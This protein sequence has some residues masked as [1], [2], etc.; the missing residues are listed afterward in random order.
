MPVVPWTHLPSLAPVAACL[1]LTVERL[2]SDSAAFP[3]GV[4]GIAMVRDGE[5][6][7]CGLSVDRHMATDGVFTLAWLA[8]PPGAG[9]DVADFLSSFEQ[10]AVWRGAARLRVS[11]RSAPDAGP[12]L[13]DRGYSAVNSNIDLRREIA[14]AP[15]PLPPGQVERTLDECGVERF[16]DLANAAFADVPFGAPL[17]LATAERMF[18]T[19]GFDRSL[20][21]VVVAGDSL[22]AFHRSSID[23]EGVGHIEALGV[24]RGARGRG[25]GRW[26]LR[27]AGQ[28]LDAAG[29]RSVQLG[30]TESNGAAYALYLAEGFIEISRREVWEAAVGGSGVL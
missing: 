28:L 1:G 23:A 30:V 19:P 25:L 7:A 21:R 2:V 4:H 29:A 24:D 12:I 3:V 10:A 26:V 20:V 15:G 13:R 11:I 22:V 16:L 17:S 9:G 14:Q 27:R 6:R 18:A 8:A 5:V